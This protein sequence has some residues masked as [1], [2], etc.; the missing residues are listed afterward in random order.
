MKFLNYLFLSLLSFLKLPHLIYS[1]P[2]SDLSDITYSSDESDPSKPFNTGENDPLRVTSWPSEMPSISL[3]P[4]QFP[5]F[6]P[7]QSPSQFPSNEPSQNPSHQPTISSQPT[8]SN[9]PSQASLNPSSFPTSSPTQIPTIAPTPEDR[10]DNYFNY[11]PTSRY[12]P[13]NWDD[14]RDGEEFFDRYVEADKRDCGDD[15]NSPINLEWKDQ[16]EDDHQIHT[17]KGSN[18]WDTNRFEVLPHALRAIF[19]QSKKPPR[20]DF[21]NLSKF[22]NA[23]Y[24]DVKLPSEH[25]MEGKQYLGEVHIGHDWESRVSFK[26]VYFIVL[27]LFQ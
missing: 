3:Q 16:C 17:E 14:L 5:S 27:L 12:G 7:S 20:A 10:P 19:K 18:D 15:H 26:F 25:V 1:Q 9:N 6:I 22:V 2:W 4:S 13:P 24:L 23:Y 8:I 21:S 11:N